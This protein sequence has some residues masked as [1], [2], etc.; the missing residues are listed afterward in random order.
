MQT[1]NRITLVN[2][3]LFVAM[4]FLSRFISLVIVYFKIIPNFL[5]FNFQRHAR[6]ILLESNILFC[7]FFCKIAAGVFEETNL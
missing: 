6:L 3:T 7:K 4:M 2:V 5:T 1:F